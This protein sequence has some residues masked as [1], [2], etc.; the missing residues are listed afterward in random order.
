M[1]RFA[2]N[3]S[4]LFPEIP[5]L[6]R[7]AAARDAGFTAV[8]FLFPY[9][10]DKAEIRE[11]RN[12]ARLAQILFNGPPGNLDAGEPGFA[13]LPQRRA[14]FKRNFEQGLDYSVALAI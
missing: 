2:A 4:M 11:R 1:P 12:E 6:E 8:E 3:L 10:F 14:E 13:A 5:F 7:F 9:S